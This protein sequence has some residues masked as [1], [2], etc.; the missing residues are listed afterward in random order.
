[1]LLQRSRD[2]LVEEMERSTRLGIP[3]VVM[4]LGAAGAAPEAEALQ[5]LADSI[6]YVLERAPAEGSRLLLETTAGQGTTLG[7]RFEHLAQ[8]LQ[9]AAAPDRVGV[10]FDTCHVFVAGYDLRDAAACEQT[11]AEFDRVVGLDRVAVIHANDAK[12]PCG[13]RVDRH[14]HVGRG[15][16]GREGFRS[17][18]SDPRLGHAAVLLET[19]K[20]GNMDPVNLEALRT[21]AAGGLPSTPVS[22]KN[23]DVV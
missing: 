4:H 21:A 20:E 5:R 16:I 11:L 3:H 1:D 9:F 7:Y 2:A 10:C 6:A 17:L 18:L 8:V 15:Q 19:P 14:D 22:N 13:S 12:K 23:H